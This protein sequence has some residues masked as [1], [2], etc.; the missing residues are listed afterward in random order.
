MHL[1]NL[2]ADLTGRE[3]KLLHREPS[4]IELAAGIDKLNVFSELASIDFLRDDMKITTAQ[5]L[6]TPYKEC[7]VRFM[8]AKE[9]ADFQ[10]RYFE[11]LKVDTK[12]KSKFADDNR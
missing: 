2:I 12:P 3:Q 1:V 5:V 8:M 7:L 10:E 11:L 9:R 4:K 6:L